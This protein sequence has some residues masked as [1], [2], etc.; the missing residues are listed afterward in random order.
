MF[1]INK[2]IMNRIFII[3]SLACLISSS[4][5]CQDKKWSLAECIDHAL[6]ENTSVKQGQLSNNVTALTLEQSKANFIPTL[7]ASGSQGFNFGRTLDPHTNVYVSQNNITNNFSVNSSY[8]L[9]TGFQ[10]INTIKMNQLNL[11]AGT[12]DLE[13]TKKDVT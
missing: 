10:T 4:A 2:I 7:S 12:L 5:F 13:K 6:Q 8:N 1:N 3:I 9:F 11:K